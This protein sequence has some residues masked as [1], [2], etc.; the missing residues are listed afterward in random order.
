MEI[1]FCRTDGLRT[2]P[3]AEN[4]IARIA[5]AGDD[6]AVFVQ[7][8]V[9]RGGINRNVRVRFGNGLHAFGRG[10]QH[11]GLDVGAALAFQQVDGGDD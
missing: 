3:R 5:Q 10:H 1:I 4:L 8:A 6:V 2:V 11:Q 7:M 9:Q